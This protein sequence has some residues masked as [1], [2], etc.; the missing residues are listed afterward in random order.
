ML[1]D[2]PVDLVYVQGQLTHLEV[3]WELPAYRIFCEQL[4]EFSRL[5]LFDKRGMGLSD[6]VPGASTLEERMDDIRAILDAVGS[7]CAALMGSSEGGP[8]ALLFAAAHPERTD[9]QWPW[10]EGTEDEFEAAMATV[11]QRWGRH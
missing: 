3:N 4:A 5:I 11:P 7:S 6:R 10:G 8:L 2:G 1:G 9:A